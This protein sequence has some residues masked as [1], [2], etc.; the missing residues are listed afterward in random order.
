M[1][2]IAQELNLSETA[3][4]FQ[5]ESDDA[6]AIRFFSPKMESALCGQATLA[7]PK[8]SSQQMLNEVHF[9][10]IRSANAPHALLDAMGLAY[11]RSLV[12]WFEAGEL[13][14]L[15]SQVIPLEHLGG[16]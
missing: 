4:L 5:G 16:N 15:L 14:C 2:Y 8:W 10:N 1:V 13:A 6:F 7:L 9:M 3:L 11:N 12:V